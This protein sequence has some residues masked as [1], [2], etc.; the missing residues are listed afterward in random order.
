M[1]KIITGILLTLVF[2][3]CEMVD[4]LSPDAWL[5]HFSRLGLVAEYQF[6]LGSMNDS[7]GN[8]LD[9]I[10]AGAL[11]PNMDKDGRTGMAISGFNNGNF[12][13]LPIEIDLSGDFTVSFWITTAATGQW[14][15]TKVHDDAVSGSGSD[16]ELKIWIDGTILRA[17]IGSTIYPNYETAASISDV[18]A[19]GWHH[20]AVSVKDTTLTVYVNGTVEG[21]RHMDHGTNPRNPKSTNPVVLG[22]QPNALGIPGSIQMGT[23]FGGTL[24]QVRFYNRVLSAS[25][26]EYLYENY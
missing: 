23:N 4:P 12:I 17:E 2:T 16:C 20:V 8:N 1:K 22:G 11:S 19:V 14:L 6:S 13:H 24:D 21:V 5:S 3:G 25:E 18:T 10:L 15:V 7:S 26:I 9:A